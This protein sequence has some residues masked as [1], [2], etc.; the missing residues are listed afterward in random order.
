MINGFLPL[1]Y[2]FTNNL[3]KVEDH[4]CTCWTDKNNHF[5]KGNWNW[6]PAFEGTDLQHKCMKSITVEM[7]YNSVM[8][9][10]NNKK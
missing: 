2:E 8:D 10:L 7:V 4:I 3:T 9:F 6:C 5:D 1:G